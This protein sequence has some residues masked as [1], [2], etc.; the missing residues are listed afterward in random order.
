MAKG[1]TLVFDIGGTKIASAVVEINAGDYVILDYQK[2]ETPGDAAGTVSMILQLCDF[3]EKKYKFRKIGIAI[4]GQVDE[5]KGEV[6][7]APNIQGFRGFRLGKKI[8]SKTGC[9]VSVRNDVRCF[10]LGEDRFGRYAGKDNAIFLAVGT[11]IGGAIKS[12]GIFQ[13]GSRGIAGEFG[14]MVVE[15][16]GELC[17]CGRKGC[18]ERY[19]SGP[20]IER[21]YLESFGREKKAKEIFSD[22]IG[23][24]SDDAAVV[25]KV[26]SYFAAGLSNLI[27]ILNPEIVVVGGSMSKDGKLLKEASPIVKS[28]VLPSARKVKIV[29]SSLGDDAFLLGA[30]L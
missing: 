27:N 2:A 14:H 13:F 17:A 24:S 15:R 26:V 16:D 4:A 5:E 7:Y 30:A 11:G 6:V 12:G 3:Y 1:K 22:A 18:W 19:V 20:G 10:A 21:M 23:G 9:A 25:E 29:H 8:S 28:E